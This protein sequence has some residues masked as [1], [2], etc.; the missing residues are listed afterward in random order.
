MA[1]KMLGHVLIHKVESRIRVLSWGGRKVPAVRKKFH[2]ASPLCW[3]SPSLAR[4]ESPGVLGMA[5]P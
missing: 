1:I 3:A 2:R 5:A 4:K